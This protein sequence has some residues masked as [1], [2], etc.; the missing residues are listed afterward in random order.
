MLTLE[1]LADGSPDCPLVLLHG[2]APHVVRDLAAAL[3][4]LARGDLELE[5][6]PGIE[7]VGGCRVTARVTRRDLGIRQVGP[8]AF[9]WELSTS[10]WDQVAGLLEPFSEPTSSDGFQWLEAKKPQGISFIIS[11]ARHW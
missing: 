4:G 9:A 2:K 10:G 7:A 1:F 6:F 11:S 8:T 3:G 5:T